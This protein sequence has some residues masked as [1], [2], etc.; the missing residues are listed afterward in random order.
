ML[1]TYCWP[2][3]IFPPLYP[4]P[5]YVDG[6]AEAD[7]WEALEAQ[8]PVDE[9]PLDAYDDAAELEDTKLLE[10]TEELVGAMLV[11]EVVGG[12]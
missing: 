5:P 4:V 12:V 10:D 7:D 2:A 3:A 9:E 1:A 11:V 6:L 8:L